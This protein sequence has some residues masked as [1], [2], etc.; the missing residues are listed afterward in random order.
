MR[1]VVC[2]AAGGA[3]TFAACGG[4]DGGGDTEAF[5]EEIV[6]VSES[7]TDT[8]AAED[9]AALQALADVAPS[10][11]SDQM[12]ELVSVFEQVQ[13]FDAEAASEEEM[14]DFMELAGSI[15]ETGVEVEEFALENCPDLPDDI[16]SIE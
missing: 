9:L 14:L 13:S 16:F 11:I 2:I 6:R 4:G 12:D 7:G 5:C 1:L 3:L 8:T 10:E 15:E